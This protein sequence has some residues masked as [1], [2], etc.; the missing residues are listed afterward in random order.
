MA[1]ALICTVGISQETRGDV[2]DALIS[3]IQEVQPSFVS[4]IVSAETRR[5]A[6]HIAVEAGVAAD[7]VEYVELATPHNLNAIFERVNDAIRRLHARGFDSADISVNYTSGT[8][9]MSSAAVLAAVFN[10]CHEV[11][12][13]FQGNGSPREVVRT[14]PEAAFAFRDLLM[15]RRLIREM[16]FQSARDL[17][18]RIDQSL[19]SSYDVEALNAMRNIAIAY[20]H[21]DNFR[22]HEFICTMDKVPRNLDTIQ[23][24]LVD[25]NVMNML[26]S[27]AHDLDE[28]RYSPLVFSDMF[29]NAVRRR[30]EG[31]YDD[32]VARIYRAMEMLAQSVLKRHDIDSDDVDT[33]R[34]PPRNRVSFEAMRSP[35]DGQIR[36]GMRKA[37]ELLA[38][39]R[40][41]LGLRFEENEELAQMLHERGQSIL[42]HGTHST[43]QDSCDALVRMVKAL[44][45][46]EIPDFQATC[47]TLQF[48]WLHKGVTWTT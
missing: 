12:Y 25:D 39:L 46:S 10:Q 4:F 21:W 19:L 32:A 6:E 44:F 34:I 22:Y 11:R 26:G 2:R 24:F 15:G 45:E 40:A 23:K 7:C 37:Y 3:E 31:Q 36:I 9:V 48:P 43:G 47:D 28:R 8:K 27:L 42:A 33:R 38:L 1:G 41:P 30:L 13:I 17:L 29:N 16:R 18:S 14:R 20:N 35:D 5:N